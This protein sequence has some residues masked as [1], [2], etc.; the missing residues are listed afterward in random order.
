MTQ[1]LTPYILPEPRVSVLIC[2]GLEVLP[3]SPI[4]DIMSLTAQISILC[5]A[6]Y[7]QNGMVIINVGNDM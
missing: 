1:P 5:L 7:Q 2:G 6:L 4:Q 3:G